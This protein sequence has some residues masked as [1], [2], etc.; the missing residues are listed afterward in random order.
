MS[1]RMLVLA[2]ILAAP[3]LATA[4]ETPLLDQAQQNQR[5]RIGQGAQSGELTRAETRHLVRQQQ[6]LHRHEN[7]AKSDGVVTP[8]ERHRLRDHARHASRSIHRQ[9]HDSQARAR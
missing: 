4:A 5:A 1:P 3:M 7:V 6:R 9:K 8:M 2:A